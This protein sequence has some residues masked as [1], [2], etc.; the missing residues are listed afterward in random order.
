M[1]A[2]LIEEWV[3]KGRKGSR[4]D[5]NYRYSNL[6]PIIVLRSRV[7]SESVIEK[8]L[9]KGYSFDLIG[10]RAILSGEFECREF[11]DHFLPQALAYLNVAK[12]GHDLYDDYIS[13][14]K[15][16]G[17]K[18]IHV[19]A[20][21]E[22]DQD[23]RQSFFEATGHNIPGIFDNE[24]CIEFQIRDNRMDNL[25]ETDARQKHTIYRENI[26]DTVIRKY[27]D[28]EE[29]KFAYILRMMFDL[30]EIIPGREFFI[31]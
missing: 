30:E 4:Q 6:A 17:Y 15:E 3:E 1:I 28:P 23:F 22:P 9:E 29:Q 20:K 2:K 31:A 10:I 26:K 7:K 14:P 21:L 13:S 11:A 19:G 25:A 8:Y 12:R 5:R 27:E 24:Y 16:T 18:S